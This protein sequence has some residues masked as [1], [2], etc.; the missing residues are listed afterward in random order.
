MR[1]AL[2]RGAGQMC[3]EEPLS[4]RSPASISSPALQTP[5]SPLKS[6]DL[7][8][9]TF[10]IPLPSVW[11]RTSSALYMPLPNTFIHAISNPGGWRSDGSER[12]MIRTYF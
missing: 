11:D 4:G 9:H 1:I 8:P 12:S 5:A 10:L 7:G 2:A 6:T 3:L